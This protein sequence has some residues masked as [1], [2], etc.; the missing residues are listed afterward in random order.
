M[1]LDPVDR[2]RVLGS[3]VLDFELGFGHTAGAGIG[4]LPIDVDRRV[5]R[6]AAPFEAR[7]TFSASTLVCGMS[8]T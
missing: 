4:G 7:A 5:G 1:Q 2:R 8:L 3:L 6:C